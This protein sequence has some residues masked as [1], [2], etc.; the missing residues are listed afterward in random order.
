MKQYQ[1]AKLALYY[2]SNIATLKGMPQKNSCRATEKKIFFAA[3][4][5]HWTE[6]NIGDLPN[7]RPLKGYQMISQLCGS[8]LCK[9]W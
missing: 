7:E 8:V 6:E 2:I 3:S 1:L 4:L 5:S 9:I